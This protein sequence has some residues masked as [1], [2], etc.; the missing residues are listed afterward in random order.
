MGQTIISAGLIVIV[1]IAVINANRLV[2]NSQTTKLEAQARL[3]AADI[4]MEIITEAR[5]KRFDEKAD[6][7][8][9]QGLAEFSSSMGRDSLRYYKLVPTSTTWYSTPDTTEMFTRPDT[10][11]F[12]SLSRYDDLDDYNGYSRVASS[13][14][15]TGYKISCK[16][17]FATQTAPD[18]P[19]TSSQYVKTI[20][21]YVTHPQYLRDTVRISMTKTY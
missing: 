9:Y 3:E 7:I 8:Y 19:T 2:I 10:H 13:T 4:A 21:V 16:V 17:Y 18:R 6:T 11:P 5:R 1:T 20:E 14:T 15:L 12:R